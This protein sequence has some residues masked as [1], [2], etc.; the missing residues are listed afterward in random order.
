M[1]LSLDCHRAGA[2]CADL[3]SKSMASTRILLCLNTVRRVESHLSQESPLASPP[4]QAA[5][6]INRMTQATKTTN[7]NNQHSQR[8]PKPPP[9]QAAP[10]PGNFYFIFLFLFYFFFGGGQK[11]GERGCTRRRV[12][13]RPAYKGGQ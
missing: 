2:G 4:W 9:T 7:A 5:L 13:K 12:S 11:G 10:S 6:G 3:L 8:A 1:D